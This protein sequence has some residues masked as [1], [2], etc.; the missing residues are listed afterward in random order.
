MNSFLLTQSQKW[1]RIISPFSLLD[2][3]PETEVVEYL[4]GKYGK[5]GNRGIDIGC[6]FGRHS[7]IAVKKGYEI[8]SVDFSREALLKTNSLLL[9]NGYYANT[10]LVSMDELL[11]DSES[12]D[13]NICWCVLNHGTKII[14]EKAISE[15]IRV[16]KKK[17]YSIGLIMSREDSRYGSGEFVEKDCYMFD[18]GLEKG[19][20][21]YFPSSDKLLTMLN[22]LG[23][24]V[25]FKRVYSSNNQL[26]FYHPG[27]SKSAHYFYILQ[28]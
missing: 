1:D 12:Y 3:E 9:L 10:K 21:H 23:R 5:L 4:N 19:I 28:K 14:F 18:R 15:S 2:K 17:G 20:C 11:F 24:I 6:G 22:S 26:R 27:L 25:E 16:L 7:L 8:V 13:F